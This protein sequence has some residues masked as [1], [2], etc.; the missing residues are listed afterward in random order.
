MNNR[1]I[2]IMLMSA[3]VI[4][5]GARQRYGTG[6]D[7]LGSREPAYTIFTA[8][9]EDPS[10]EVSVSWAGAVDAPG[11][12]VRYTTA[13]DT[14]WMRGITVPGTSV[15]C[16]VYDSIF[17]KLA[18]NTD[19]YER[20]V[21]DKYGAT[22]SGLQPSTDYI[23]TVSAPAPDGGTWT[24]APRRLRTAPGAGSSWRAAVIGDYHH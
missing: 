14:A 5:A 24:S 13:D 22:L 17:S 2:T 20:H 10:H 16:N 7:S 21:F 8:V 12:Y 11:Q 19:V 6:L 9:G 23:Y 4:S 15:R 3:A 18:D 1:F